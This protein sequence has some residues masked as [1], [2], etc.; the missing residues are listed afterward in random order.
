MNNARRPDAKE[1]RD[2][3]GNPLRRE[4][5][6]FRTVTAIFRTGR[7]SRP[8]YNSSEPGG[9]VGRRRCE[10]RP[11]RLL[12]R[13]RAECRCD[14]DT[15]PGLLG[16]MTLAFPRPRSGPELGPVFEPNGYRRLCA[17]TRF[18]GPF[19]A[20]LPRS[21]TGLSRAVRCQGPAGCV[22]RALADLGTH[23]ERRAAATGESGHGRNTLGRGAC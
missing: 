22:K 14:T 10:R 13:M 7:L 4:S 19:L 15:S 23:A 6:R 21:R 5:G 16:G 8:E 9:L 2:E 20:D 1:P 3:I 17:R 12:A 11:R 18:S